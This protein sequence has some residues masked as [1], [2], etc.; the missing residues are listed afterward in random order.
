[1]MF[2]VMGIGWLMLSLLLLA[3]PGVS[4]FG[5]LQWDG[6]LAIGFLSVFLFGDGLCILVRCVAG[7]T[8]W[9]AGRLFVSGASGQRTGSGFIVE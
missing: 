5:R 8:G 2:F 4:E 6:W 3:G 1:M 9:P 7:N